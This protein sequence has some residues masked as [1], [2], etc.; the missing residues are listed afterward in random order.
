MKV[1]VRD[2]YCDSLLLS[3]F[4][5]SVEDLLRVSTVCRLWSQISRS[6]ALWCAF[7]NVRW[8]GT[9]EVLRPIAASLMEGFRGL[10]RNRYIAEAPV[11]DLSPCP[12]LFVPADHFFALTVW[13]GTQLIHTSV[14]EADAVLQESMQG[15][16]VG[17]GDVHTAGFVFPLG[18]TGVVIRVDIGEESEHKRIF[19]PR[20]GQALDGSCDPE[21]IRDD[22]AQ[23]LSFKVVVIRKRDGSVAPLFDVPAV[24][25][26]GGKY[27]VP[28]HFACR[29]ATNPLPDMRKDGM[30][31][32]KDAALHEASGGYEIELNA[33]VSF[34]DVD[35][36]QL[37]FVAN[38]RPTVDIID[39][40]TCRWHRIHVHLSRD[41]VRYAN[42]DDSDY[43]DHREEIEEGDIS[44]G[45]QFVDHTSDLAGT[46]EVW[47]LDDLLSTLAAR[48]CFIGDEH[49]P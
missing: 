9:I 14:Q 24:R 49:G 48:L 36:V 47:T 32:W 15:V 25:F 16:G 18:L 35:R 41:C 27:G 30:C 43:E 3:F 4:G 28:G 13:Q 31:Q 46:T 1:V 45:M 2:W 8:P 38:P 23:E 44:A 5:L 19:P 39:D 29:S 42:P 40:R 11:A 34:L 12:P 7:Y 10:F 6:S 20:P 33:M 17:G 37:N 21:N 26:S 22:D